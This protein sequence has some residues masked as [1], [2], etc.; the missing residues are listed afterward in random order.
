MDNAELMQNAHRLA[1]LR[2]ERNG[3]P[4]DNADGEIPEIEE[5][6]DIIA[7]RQ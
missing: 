5:A 3:V 4:V 7:S 1:I 2:A 6:N